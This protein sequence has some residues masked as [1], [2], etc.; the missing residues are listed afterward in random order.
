MYYF[1]N[2]VNLNLRLIYLIKYY[3]IIKMDKREEKSLIE[4]N[5]L[6]FNNLNYI[7][8]IEN[9]RN[10]G[11]DIF[12]ILS[13]INVIILHI[14]K[15]SDLIFLPPKS[16]KY[17]IIWNLEISAYWAVNGFGLISGFINYKKYKF[18][19]LFYIWIEVLFYSVSISFIL[20]MKK[21]ISLNQLLI[22]FFPLLI[23]RHWYINA[24]FSMYL[25]LPFIIEGIKNIKKNIFRNIIIFFFVYFSLYNIVA[26]IINKQ[27]YN[28]LNNGYSP[29]WLTILYIIGAYFGKNVINIENKE[30]FIYYIFWILIYI[31]LSIFTLIIF[32]KKN[33]LNSLSNNLFVDYISPT[34]LLQAI[35]LLMFF[36]KF[37]IQKNLT[38]KIISFFSSLNF[39]AIL[40]HGRLF[41]T[42]NIV[43]KTFF[44]LVRNLNEDYLFIKIYSMAIFIYILC[45][46]IDYFRFLLFKLL[47]IR[48]FCQLIEKKFE[49]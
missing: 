36:S 12:K 14:N 45:I 11:I 18:S 22:S 35:S 33:I 6:I 8:P 29:I 28:F 49:F 32:L 17:R 31:F 43:T 30:K 10:Y 5:V 3:I 25:F 46:F 47:K 41:Q 34:I 9:K 2:Q 26:K 13:T 39:S 16:S 1:I 27:E 21:E 40:I 48:Y 19:N 15:H 7:K 42:K 4:N 37:K 23:K 38:K 24:Y 20:F 44:N